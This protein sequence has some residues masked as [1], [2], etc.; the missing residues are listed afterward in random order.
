[1]KHSK[2][3]HTIKSEWCFV[4]I[5]GSL[6]VVVGCVSFSKHRFCLT[7]NGDTVC[8]ITYEPLVFTG[9]MGSHLL[10]Y[11]LRFS[12]QALFRILSIKTVWKGVVIYGLL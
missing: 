5:E 11:V 1:M 12:G 7:N 10:V 4:C 8:K 3:L 6:A 2:K 9:I